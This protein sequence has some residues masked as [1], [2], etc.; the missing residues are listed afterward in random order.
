MQAIKIY[1]LCKNYKNVKALKG[2]SFDIQKGELFGLLGENGAGKTTLIKILCMLTKKTS[3]SVFINGLNIDTDSQK[4]KEIID[5]SPQET[6]VANNLTVYENLEFFANIYG[7]DKLKID[8]V[9][10]FFSLEEV[11]NKKAR[12]L[13]GGYKRRLSIAIAL[14]SSPKI[15]FLDEPT[16]GLDVISRRELWKIISK[17]KNKITIILT[18]HYLEEIDALCDRVAILQKGNLL[19]LGTIEYIK[20]STNSKTLEDAFIKIVEGENE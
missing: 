14:L 17:L 20:Q 1:N 10:E 15:L 2:V 18:S 6:S 13:S 9:I 4:I 3:G 19:T 12:T 16:L 5:I 7:G 11:L 8:E